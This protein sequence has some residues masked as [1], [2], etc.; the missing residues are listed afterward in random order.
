MAAN[1]DESAATADP[2]LLHCILASD[3]ARPR[4][5]LLSESYIMKLSK[6]D[7]GRPFIVVVG[8]AITVMVREWWW[9]GVVVSA[10]LTKICMLQFRV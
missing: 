2:P 9:V 7:D 6:A 4:P 3:R 5:V 1:S 8:S 10:V